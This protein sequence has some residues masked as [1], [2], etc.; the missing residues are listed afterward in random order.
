MIGN[1]LKTTSNNIA[2]N[3][4]RIEIEEVIKEGDEDQ[5]EAVKVQRPRWMSKVRIHRDPL[6]ESLVMLCTPQ[7]SKNRSRKNTSLNKSRRMHCTPQQ[8]K[9]RPRKNTPQNNSRPMHCTPQQRKKKS[10]KNTPQ[11]KSRCKYREGDISQTLENKSTSFNKIGVE[12]NNKTNK[13]GKC[14]PLYL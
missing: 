2:D 6:I 14:A 4:D 3:S 1:D 8:R 10:R 7:H 13:I 11:N 9:K 5:N 12:S